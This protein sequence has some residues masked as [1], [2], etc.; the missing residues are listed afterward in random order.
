MKKTIKITKGKDEFIEI[1][2]LAEYCRQ[3]GYS[4]IEE[5]VT[6]KMPTGKELLQLKRDVKTGKIKIIE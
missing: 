2:A 3:R 5:T 1:T 4:I 6:I